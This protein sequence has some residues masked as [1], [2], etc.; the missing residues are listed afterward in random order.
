MYSLGDYMEVKILNNE[1][2]LIEFE[3]QDCEQAILQ[4]IVEK[5][6]KNSNVEFAAY[7]LDHPLLS[8]PTMI[9]QTK[10]GDALD[11]VLE[12]LELLSKDFVDL[13]KQLKS[14]LK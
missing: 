13:K 8:S 6:N 11:F 1:K 7:R 9:V 14:A 3:V 2:K 4:H 10:K 5:L 12:E